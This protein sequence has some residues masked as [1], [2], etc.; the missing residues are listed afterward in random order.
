MRAAH[1]SDYFVEPALVSLSFLLLL[2]GLHMVFWHVFLYGFT[3]NIS[4][5][6]SSNH[7][8]P[9]RI[10]LQRQPVGFQILKQQPYIL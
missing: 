4:G 5:I 2:T 1:A 9:S 6:H 3:Q 10:Q 7:F 8:I